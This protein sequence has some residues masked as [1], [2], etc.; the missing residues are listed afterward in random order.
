[1][2]DSC[3]HLIVYVWASDSKVNVLLQISLLPDA[4]ATFTK[5]ESVEVNRNRTWVKIDQ[6][7]SFEVSNPEKFSDQKVFLT[8]W[9]RVER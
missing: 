6:K 5:L 8:F 9:K 1:M 7:F 3:Y 4:E 2:W